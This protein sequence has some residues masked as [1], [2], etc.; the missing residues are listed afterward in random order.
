MP[1]KKS[2]LQIYAG[3]DREY[4][5]HRVGKLLAAEQMEVKVSNTLTSIR[6]AVGD[7]SVAVYKA[8]R[9]G[10]GGNLGKYL[11]NGICVFTVYCVNGGNVLLGDHEHVNGCLRIYVVESEHCIV[12]IDL[13]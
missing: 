9:L 1:N 8:C 12:L 5:A 11:C 13:A 3:S 4:S 7:Y 6:T 2:P 10:N